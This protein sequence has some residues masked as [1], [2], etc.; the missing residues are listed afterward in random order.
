[1]L[2]KEIINSFFL[3]CLIMIPLYSNGQKLSKDNEVSDKNIE[4]V[5]NQVEEYGE[6]GIKHRNIFILA[7]EKVFTPGYLEKFF[8]EYKNKYSKPYDLRIVIYSDK[9][10]IQRLIDFRKMDPIEFDDSDAGKKA[11]SE[12]HKR[13]YPLTEGY[14]RAEY[15]RYGKYEFFQY[16]PKKESYEMIRTSLKTDK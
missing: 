5:L 7:D 9:E 13:Y 8:A 4:I 3:F 2:Y 10:M 11:A 14:W 16:S 12:Y 1:M 6:S 15:F